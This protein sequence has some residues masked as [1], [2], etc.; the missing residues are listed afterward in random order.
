MRVRCGEVYLQWDGEVWRDVRCGE[1]MSGEV[2]RYGVA[3]WPHSSPSS[4]VKLHHVPQEL[5]GGD[6]RCVV[7]LTA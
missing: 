6:T 5:P 3:R 4:L 1:M 7:Q 2:Y